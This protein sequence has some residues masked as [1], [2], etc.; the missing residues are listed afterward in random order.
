MEARQAYALNVSLLTSLI[1]FLRRL[2]VLERFQCRLSLV[3][4]AA[5]AAQLQA[6]VL[7]WVSLQSVQGNVGMQIASGL[8]ATSLSWAAMTLLVMGSFSLPSRQQF[9]SLGFYVLTE[10]SILGQVQLV[11]G[12]R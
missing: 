4:A 10:L 12:E 5:L 7:F 2:F 1:I 8:A 3:T 9:V 6:G 11:L